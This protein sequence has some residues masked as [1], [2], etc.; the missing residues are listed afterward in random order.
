MEASFNKLHVNIRQILALKISWRF[1]EKCTA[2]KYP[3]LVNDMTLPSDNL[4]RLKEILQ[5]K[6]FRIEHNKIVLIDDQVKDEKLQYDVN[7]EAAKISALSSD[8]I[9]KYEYLNGEEILPSN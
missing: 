9:D 3:L 5:K 1:I 8:K 4:L 2:E 6:L 7:T